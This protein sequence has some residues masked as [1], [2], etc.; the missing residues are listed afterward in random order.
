MIHK[1]YLVEENFQYIKNNLILFYGENLGLIDDFKNKIID[2]NKGHQILRFSQDEILKNLDV[3]IQEIKNVSLFND[4]KIFLIN[5]ANDKILKV[6][7]EITPDI[8]ENKFFLFAE[9]LD[10]KSKLR[11]FFEKEKITDIIPCYEDNY[12]SLKNITKKKLKDYTGLTPEIINTI[13]EN[14]NNNRIKL[15]NEIQKIKIYFDDKIIDYNKLMDLLNLQENENFN[16][17]KDS[18]FNGKNQNT[19]RLL[20]TTIIETEKSAL[21]VASIYQRLIKLREIIDKNTDNNIENTISKIKP[22]IFWKDKPTIIN[23]AK[24]WNKDK[25]N[26]AI[27]ITYDIELKIKS[28]SN[29]DRKIMLKKLIVDVCNLANS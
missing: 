1:S 16:N 6:I 19:N 14:C 20:N 29:L 17:V 11:N 18:A 22:P 15:K 27:N 13:I 9:I 7:Q 5:N 21:Y 12:L 25:L 23:Q 8:S 28:N 4:K 24:I 10:K 3:F 26:K 2:I